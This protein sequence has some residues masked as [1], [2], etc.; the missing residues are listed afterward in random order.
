[1]TTFEDFGP[2][3]EG[4]GKLVDISF[5]QWARDAGG[6]L[7]IAPDFE[8]LKQYFDGGIA[9]AGSATLSSGR[10]YSDYVFDDNL[11]GLRNAGFDPLGAYWYLRPGV[12]VEGQAVF[13]AN[14]V[15][16]RGLDV[17]VVDVEEAGP[18]SAVFAFLRAFATE[19]TRARELIPDLWIYTGPWAW[20]RMS[21]SKTEA[22]NYELWVA[23]Y[24]VDIPASVEPW[25]SANKLPVAHQFT[26][27]GPGKDWGVH[28]A[29]LDLNWAHPKLFE[30]PSPDPE[31]YPT[32]FVV[33][34]RLRAPVGLNIRNTPMVNSI[35]RIGTAPPG[36]VFEVV[37][38]APDPWVKIAVYAHGYYLK[39]L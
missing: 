3:V 4:A 25:A 21:G 39:D 34:D 16:G 27:K 5:W 32:E 15:K 35:N 2:Y 11:Q 18:A 8:Q 26:D 6:N 17:F 9:R 36:M 29:G 22:L 33:V 38:R 12:N 30:E 37:E 1:M 10:P 7:S 14:L 19:L 20:S 24:E 28:S 31:P 13:A 23:N